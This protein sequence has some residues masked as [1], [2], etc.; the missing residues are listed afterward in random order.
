LARC[1]VFAGGFDLPGA[2]SF[3]GRWRAGGVRGAGCAGPKVAGD[4]GRTGKA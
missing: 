3:A 2:P 1:S 4:R